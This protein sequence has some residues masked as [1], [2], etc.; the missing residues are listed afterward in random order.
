MPNGADRIGCPPA[1]HD[2]RNTGRDRLSDGLLPRD[3]RRVA[4]DRAVGN[5]LDK[6]GISYGDSVVGQLP[7]GAPA[8]Q[9]Q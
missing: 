5:L 8:A 3:Q 2:R 9:Q 6:N 7:A 1:R 4:L